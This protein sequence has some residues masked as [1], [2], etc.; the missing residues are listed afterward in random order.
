MITTITNYYLIT[1]IYET[2]ESEMGDYNHEM[3]AHQKVIVSLY[4]EVH[5]D[6]KRVPSIAL[7][8]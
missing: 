3:P 4:L 5:K 7:H 2:E 8:R 6:I 1:D